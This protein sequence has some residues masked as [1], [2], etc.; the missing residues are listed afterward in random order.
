MDG[1]NALFKARTVAFLTNNLL[2]PN[3]AWGLETHIADPRDL[4]T[5]LQTFDILKPDEGSHGVHELKF[6]DRGAQHLHS[7]TMERFDKKYSASGRTDSLWDKVK[8][9]VSEAR[10]TNEPPIMAF[11][12]P[13]KMNRTFEMDLD[14]RAD[15]F[16][17][18][19]LSGCTVVVSGN[20]QQPHAAHIN[21]MENTDLPALMDRFRPKR[22]STDPLGV[23]NLD[24][25][26]EDLCPTPPETVRLSEE[27]NPL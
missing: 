6:F 11:W 18:A 12:L 1:I 15:F 19:G 4:Q 25:G 26:Y 22:I 7:A 21:R 20:P 9:T 16:F 8:G 27:Q 23:A 2:H 3:P 14:N 17:A 10:S 5:G 24:G 13:F